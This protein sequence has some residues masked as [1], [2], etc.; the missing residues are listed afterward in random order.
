MSD[1]EYQALKADI[2]EH[3]VREPIW[4]WR[5]TVLDGRHRER[6][7]DELGIPVPARVYEGDEASLVPFV[8]SLNLKRR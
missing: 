3:G 5:G 1:A 8:V 7:C 2:A 4:T 6:A